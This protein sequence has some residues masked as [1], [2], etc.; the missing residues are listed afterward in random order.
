VEQLAEFAADG[1]AVVGVRAERDDTETVS[2]ETASCM[3]TL[4]RQVAASAVDRIRPVG[5]YASGGDVATGTIAALGGDGFQIES[6]VL[7]LAVVGSVV[8]GSHG[9]LGF[10][11]KGGLVGGPDAAILCVEALQTRARTHVPTILART[12]A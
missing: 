3:L 1:A 4:L 6:E 2:P 5:V 8:G 7:P 11:T 10:A 9:G 12:Q